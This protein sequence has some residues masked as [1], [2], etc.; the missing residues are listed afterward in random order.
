MANELKGTLN[1]SQGQGVQAP[2]SELQNFQTVMREI[3]RQAYKNQAKKDVKYSALAGAG[4][5][6][7]DVSG[8]AFSSIMG[9]L[10]QMRGG[11][12]SKEYAAGVQGY[13]DTLDAIEKQRTSREAAGGSAM[14]NMKKTLDLIQ[15]YKDAGLEVPSALYASIGTKDPDALP[16]LSPEDAMIRQTL[17]GKLKEGGQFID[18]S[19]Y[20][21]AKNDY[22]ELKGKDD[23][24]KLIQSRIEFDEKFSDMLDP[25][26]LEE[27]K[28][29]GIDISL[30]EKA[31]K[32]PQ[33]SQY[34]L[35]ASTD[36][37]PTI[38]KDKEAKQ[39]IDYYIKNA[40]FPTSYQLG[41]GRTSNSAKQ[42]AEASQRAQDLYFK[43]TGTSL[44]D[45]SVLKANKLLVNANNKILNNQAVVGDAIIRNFDLAINGE[46]TN[47]VNKNATIVNKIL[48]P[49]YMA[50]GDPAV[51]QAMVSNG[52]IS[53][54]FANLISIRNASGTTV[55]D[56]EMA[57]EL[58]AFGTSVDAQKAVVERLKAEAANIHN[59]IK[60]QNEELYK[61][62]DP[63]ETELAN[64]N[65]QKKLGDYK[66]TTNQ[67]TNMFITAPDGVEYEIID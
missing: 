7:S 51:N 11:D 50:L 29:S 36:F 55:A 23:P 25:T 62:I 46:I 40:A 30:S 41:M 31:K 1:A 17:V 28:K 64:P 52:T 56:K 48:N 59:A 37:N 54:E 39:Y 16:D 43:A 61:I 27:Y 49:I 14:E 15:S 5:K 44:P 34:G 65:R 67:R 33:Y 60:I 13:K 3:S 42:F 20:L 22:T 4:A 18:T 32:I 38:Q 58:I 35:L 6:P 63:L 47:D 66:T 24:Q 45:A 21:K 26:K 53:Q 2:A 57:N 9:A 8:S 19:S 10:E 12:I